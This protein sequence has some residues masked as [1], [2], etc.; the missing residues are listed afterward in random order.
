MC[1][2]VRCPPTVAHSVS[3]GNAVVFGIII[4]TF[5]TLRDEEKDKRQDMTSRCFICGI[6][7]EEFDRHGNGF[8]AHI[9]ADHNMWQ[10][11]FLVV[12][13]RSKED[14]E[15]DGLESYVKNML[16]DDDHAWFPMSKVSCCCC[17]CCCSCCCCCCCCFVLWCRSDW[18]R[19]HGDV[20]VLVSQAFVLQQL[21]DTGRSELAVLQTQVKSVASEV[22]VLRADV[23]K[24]AAEFAR[25][26]QRLPVHTRV[27]R[28]FGWSL[29]LSSSRIVV[30]C[31]Q[32][33]LQRRCSAFSY[34]SL[35]RNSSRF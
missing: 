35:L 5:G 21:E 10:Y 1:P 31:R 11:L 30:M 2:S 24:V 8:V 4:D 12:H 17:C 14:T 16:A 25:T 34:S 18:P 32:P 27:V 3:S 26:V 7:R 6:S 13:L 23:M 15:M 33:A 22:S 29:C 9:K 20:C 19:Y 28:F